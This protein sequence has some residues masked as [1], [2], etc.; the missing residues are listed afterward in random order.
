MTSGDAGAETAF[1]AGRDHHAK[2]LI[3]LAWPSEVFLYL[4]FSPI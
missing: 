2:P 3:C 1:E 4:P